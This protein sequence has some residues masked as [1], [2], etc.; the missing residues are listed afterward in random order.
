MRSEAG[1]ERPKSKPIRRCF[2]VYPCPASMYLQC[3]AYAKGLNCWDV[4]D[5]PCC[6]RKDLSRCLNCPVYIAAHM[7][8]GKR[9]PTREG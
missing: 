9:K 3:E 6:K 5:K 2:E 8:E 7:P 1:M 4:P